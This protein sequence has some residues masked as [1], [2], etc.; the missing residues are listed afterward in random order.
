MHMVL[1]ICDWLNNKRG[2]AGNLQK[3]QPAIVNTFGQIMHF[4]K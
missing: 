1:V 2:G 3:F 4:N